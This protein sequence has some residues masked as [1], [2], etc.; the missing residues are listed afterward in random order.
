MHRTVLAYACAILILFASSAVADGNTSTRN[1]VKNPGFEQMDTRRNWP[2]NWGATRI[3]R[4]E[5]AFMKTKGMT[6]KRALRLG[7]KGKDHFYQIITGFTKANREGPFLIQLRSKADPGAPAQKVL[8]L[9][10]AFRCQLAD[11]TFKMAY[12]IRQGLPRTP[13]WQT[14]KILWTPPGPL[15]QVEMRLQFQGE[16]F[17]WFDDFLVAKVTADDMTE[18]YALAE[19]LLPHAGSKWKRNGETWKTVGAPPPGGWYLRS[20]RYYDINRLKLRLRKQEAKG[21]AYLYTCGLRIH[22]REKDM[23][24]A[25][26]DKWSY[27]PYTAMREINFPAGTWQDF[28]LGFNGKDISVAWNGKTVLR[29]RSPQEEW[30]KIVNKS[31]KVKGD[32]YVFPPNLPAAILEGKNQYVILHAYDTSLSLDKAE[33]RG[34]QLGEVK[35]FSGNQIVS[36]GGMLDTELERLA[37]LTPVDVKWKLPAAESAK[38]TKL[39]KVAAWE[40]KDKVEPKK[41]FGE[42]HNKTTELVDY[43]V[44]ARQPGKF[45]LYLY[46]HQR[47]YHYGPRKMPGGVRIYF[48]LAQSGTYTLKTGWEYWGIGWG[49]NVLEIRVDGKPVSREVYRALSNNCF[50]PATRDYVPLE[51]TAGPHRIDLHLKRDLAKKGNYLTKYLRIPLNEVALVKGVHEPVFERNVKR[52]ARWQ[53]KTQAWTDDPKVGEQY[54]KII[55]YRLT[56]LKKDQKYKLTLGFYEVDARAPGERL[57]ELAINGKT[58]E[59]NLD[60]YKEFS[61]LKYGEKSY[62]ATA[63]NGEI[64]FKLI[65]R[66]FKAFLNCFKLTDSRGRQAYYENCGWSPNLRTKHT[67]DHYRPLELKP[68]PADPKRWTGVSQDLFD[69]HNMIANPHFTLVKGGKP[70]W[71]QPMTAFA[72][73][74]TIKHYRFYQ[75]NGEYSHD[76]KAGC[77]KPG[78][79]RIGKTG[80]D[81]ALSP[82]WFSVDYDKRQ[83]FS[84]QCKTQGANGQVFA[85]IIWL[86]Q[87]MDGGLKRKPRLRFIGRHKGKASTGTRG[88]HTVAVT[89]N[90]PH[91]ASYAI[92]L[93]RVENNTAGTVWVD[94]AEFNG[95]G[96]E[97]LEIMTS[98]FGYHPRSDK[99]IV[100]RS[101]AKGPVNWILSTADGKR[102]RGGKAKYH[103]HEWFSKRHYYT[104]D[105]SALSA[106]GAYTLKV[107]QSGAAA[108]TSIKVNKSTYQDLARM[109]ASALRRKRFNFNDPKGTA[110]DA[111]EDAQMLLE[112]PVPSLGRYVQYEKRFI[113]GRKEM[114]G[115][116]YD[117]GDEMK[118]LEFWPTALLAGWSLNEFASL[119]GKAGEDEMLWAFSALHKYVTDDGM[120]YTGIKP[121]VRH[122]DNIPFTGSNDRYASNPRAVSQTAGACALAAW[123]TRDSDK[124]LSKA[125]LEAALRNY[126]YNWKAWHKAVPKPSTREEFLFKSKALLAEVFISKLAKDEIYEKRMA[127]HARTVAAGLEKRLYANASELAQANFMGGGINQDFVLALCLLLRVHPSHPTA[128]EIKA[129]LRAFADDVKRVSAIEPW[130]QAMDLS[131]PPGKRPMRNP[132]RVRPIGYWPGL[133]TSLAWI[134]MTLNDAETVKL[135]E[136]QLQWCLGKNMANASAIHGTSDRVFAGGDKMYNRTKFVRDWFASKRNLYT[137]DGLVP[138]MAFRD[139]G[140]G[141]VKE[142]RSEFWPPLEARPAGMY[143]VYLQASYPTHPGPSEFYLPQTC[144]FA[145]AAATIHYALENVK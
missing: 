142:S 69:G 93:V 115:G 104:L 23:F 73:H 67:P 2:K 83:S 44:G 117:A 95:Y 10:L 89:A 133:A 122:S 62:E 7:G 16:G 88:W 15:K 119:P 65:G 81:F 138:S 36:H 4:T 105:L 94:D 11:G 131:T 29:W 27:Y 143:R 96:A 51:L 56:G 114:L 43:F 135:G 99:T 90:P 68:Q 134:G 130:G 103:S 50:G 72:K 60:I 34:T 106:E 113:S 9:G 70:E 120:V 58:V 79:M 31:G 112:A 140:D 40:I 13:D 12:P 116:Y 39:P 127:K 8:N 19:S 92:P 118:H 64:E 46:N 35:S 100:V 45:P 38:A 14:T 91:G 109:T 32:K 84:F 3:K 136:R 71:W 82:P 102:L 121:Q 85:E 53:N 48:N 18:K 98:H 129:G 86:A 107:T 108:N 47:S 132:I 137:Y 33:V 124:A 63:A 26:A 128:P 1:L 126:E 20:K 17:A 101:I 54:G 125:N 97:K 52:G 87:D 55:A 22:L 76:A 6:G 49:P 42:K 61:W 78:S 141:T 66:N 123:K 24:V 37:P 30:D 145:T 80:K 57:M 41:H 139:M 110:A 21:T 25:L 74:S 59:S 77:A 28:E 75:G 144:D 5:S 111:L